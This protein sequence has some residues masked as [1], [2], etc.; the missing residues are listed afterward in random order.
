MG[1]ARQFDDATA[2][3]GVGVVQFG[4]DVG[5]GER[6]E[7]W[8]EVAGQP[9]IGDEGEREG[10]V[11]VAVGRRAAHRKLHWPLRRRWCEERRNVDGVDAGLAQ[12]C[13]ESIDA[14]LLGILP[15]VLDRIRVSVRRE[16]LGDAQRYHRS[17]R[18]EEAFVQIP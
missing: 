9:K 13:D 4:G 17:A 11:E 2:A 18:G 14:L 16:D 12:Q 7:V 8:A 3:C 1:Y 15:E 5:I 6:G 10:E